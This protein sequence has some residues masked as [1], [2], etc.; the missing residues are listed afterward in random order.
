MIKLPKALNEEGELIDILNPSVKSGIN[1][2][3]KCPDPFCTV[4]LIAKKGRIKIAHFAHKASPDKCGGVETALHLLTKEVLSNSLEFHLP[5]YFKRF[6]EIYPYLK[7]EIGVIEKRIGFGLPETIYE[8]FEFDILLGPLWKIEVFQETAITLQN[9]NI[10]VER[11][12]M[13][14]TPDIR[15]NIPNTERN[16][17]LEIFVTHKV[18]EV[19]IKKIQR[20][21][22]C[23]L[24]LDLS[25]HRKNIHHI[26]QEF[27]RKILENKSYKANWISFPRLEHLLVKNKVRILQEIELR[28]KSVMH[29]YK[30]FCKKILKDKITFLMIDP[31]NRIRLQKDLKKDF[32]EFEHSNLFDLP[33][34]VPYL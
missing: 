9:F 34:I 33:N 31:Y 16:L 15:I 13:E 10:Y 7:K 19:K 22:L 28:L 4:P 30:D 17:Y 14:M 23:F 12:I 5:P 20:D 6:S 25:T 18:D 29:I 32:P 24:E 27:I 1:P 21:N 8:S 3:L 2:G 11:P 26:N